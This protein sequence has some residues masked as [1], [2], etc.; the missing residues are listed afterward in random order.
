MDVYIW[1]ILKIN[2]RTTNAHNDTERHLY[3]GSYNYQNSK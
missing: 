3:F 2:L 1:I